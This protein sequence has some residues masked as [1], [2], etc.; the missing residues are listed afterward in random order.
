MRLHRKPFSEQNIP[1]LLRFC[2]AEG[3]AAR[4]TPQSHCSHWLFLA[5]AL[6]A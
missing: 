4:D 5:P 1:K 6:P 2:A 3:E